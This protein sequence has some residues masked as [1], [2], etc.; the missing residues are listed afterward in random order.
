MNGTL[1]LTGNNSIIRSIVERNMAHAEKL[2]AGS[3]FRL[4]KLCKRAQDLRKTK[5]AK[6]F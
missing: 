6:E 2:C 5:G 3:E 1:I 4:A